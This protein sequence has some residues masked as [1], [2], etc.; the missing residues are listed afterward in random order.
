MP[1]TKTN[2]NNPIRGIL[3]PNAGQKSDCQDVIAKLTFADLGRGPGTLHTSG[4][5]RLDV[6]GV[7]PTA[8]NLQVQI[9]NGSTAAALIALT[10][11]NTT[12]PANQ[13]GVAAGVISVLNQ[14]L[15]SGTIWN[16][17]GSLP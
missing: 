15:D 14:S 13:R 3:I 10:V 2:S 1:L 5:A 7:T 16:L 8:V 11:Q 6:Q 9:G 17:T 4:V 12:D